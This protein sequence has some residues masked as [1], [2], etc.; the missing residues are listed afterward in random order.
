MPL[1]AN[2]SPRR[3]LAALVGLALVLALT[4]C[5]AV[6]DFVPPGT[7]DYVNEAAN[8][9]ELDSAGEFQAEGSYGGSWL[10][11]EGPTYV[12]VIA[13]EQAPDIIAARLLELGYDHMGAVENIESWERGFDDTFLQVHVVH[14]QPGDEATIRDGENVAVEEEGAYL[15]ITGA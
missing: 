13:G 14:V 3:S 15:T 5:S 1:L 7:F 2:S 9:L 12:A 6:E 4:G 11:G 10:W 8:E